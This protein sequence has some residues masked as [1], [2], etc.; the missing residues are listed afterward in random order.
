M[1]LTVQCARCHD[2]KYDPIPIEDYYSLYGVFHGSEDRLVPL[3]PDEQR[4][5]REERLIRSGALRP[6]P[7]PRRPLGDP[8]VKRG[9]GRAALDALIADRGESH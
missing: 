7:G 9:S 3:A 2:H 5:T 6:A 8:K 4:A 1:A